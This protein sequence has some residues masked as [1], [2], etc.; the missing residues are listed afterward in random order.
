MHPLQKGDLKDNLAVWGTWDPLT[1]LRQYRTIGARIR[2]LYPVVEEL[3]PIIA[4]DVD[5]ICARLFILLRVPETCKKLVDLQ[6]EQA[7][8]MVDLLQ[9][10]CLAFPPRYVNSKYSYDCLY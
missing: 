9:Q 3:H 7:Q 5:M 4:L 1:S 8:E 2:P 10:V 6:K